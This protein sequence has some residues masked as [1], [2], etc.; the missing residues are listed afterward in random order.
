MRVFVVFAHI[1][2]DISYLIMLVNSSESGLSCAKRVW[3]L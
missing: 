2:S 3:T 1:D